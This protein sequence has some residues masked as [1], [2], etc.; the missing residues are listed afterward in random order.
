MPSSFGAALALGI[1][2]K[3]VN[4]LSEKLFIL[5]PIYT[6]YI[7]SI[8]YLSMFYTVKIICGKV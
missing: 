8:Y 6:T 5:V 7:V 4:V 2:V 3:T 1:F